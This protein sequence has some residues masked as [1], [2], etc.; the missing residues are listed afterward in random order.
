MPLDIQEKFTQMLVMSI[1]QQ[2]FSWYEIINTHG[3][4]TLLGI[5]LEKKKYQI[6]IYFCIYLYDG[7]KTL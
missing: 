3:F 2:S 6:D 5:Y 4:T 1:F 7:K